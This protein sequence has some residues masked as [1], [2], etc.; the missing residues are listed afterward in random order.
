MKNQNNIIIL[1]AFL[2]ILLLIPTVCAS[3]LN[4][5]ADSA[6]LSS[7]DATPV[8]VDLASSD[9][10][11]IDE[12]TD[13][14]LGLS[15]E[16]N[17]T[18]DTD[19]MDNAKPVLKSSNEE[20][21]LSATPDGT[22]ADLK[23]LIAGTGWGKT[24]VLD[25][26][27]VNTDNEGPIIIPRYMTI[28]GN[29]YT[30]DALGKSRIF[31]TQNGDFNNNLVLKN[32][33]FKN[34]YSI[35]W[36]GAILFQNRLNRLVIEDCTFINCTSTTSNGAAILFSKPVTNS[37]ISATFI[38]N[39]AS[40]GFS[41]FAF[42]SQAT[43]D[44]CRFDLTF[45][46]NT[47]WQAPAA[48][49]KAN[50][51]NSVFNFNLSGNVAKN[52][53]G[54]VYFS[55]NLS[56]V[57]ITGT[58]VNNT[59]GNSGDG[60]GGALYFS[61][62]LRDV[63]I[64]GTFIGNRGK[65]RYAGAIYSDGSMDNVNITG[66]FENNTANFEGGAIYARS[67]IRNLNIDGT[68]ISNHA[69]GYGGGAIDLGD[70]VRYSTIGGTFIGNTG[71]NGG[72]IRIYN[73]TYYI[74]ITG[75]FTDNSATCGGAI[76]L[77][78]SY[79]IGIGATF[80]DNT[81]DYGGA[82]YANMS[83][84]HIAH[85]S[86]TGNRAINGSAIYYESSQSDIDDVTFDQNQAYSYSLPIVSNATHTGAILYGGDNILNAIYNSGDSSQIT[87]DGVTVVDGAENSQGGTIVYQDTREYNQVINISVYDVLKEST[88]DVNGLTDIYGKFTIPYEFKDDEWY[89]ISA[90]HPEDNYYTGIS[91]TSSVHLNPGLNL[92]NHT[93]YEGNFSGQKLVSAL[94]D[95]DLSSIPN[96]R[97]INYYIVLDG[98]Y[99]F[100]GSSNTNDLGVSSIV[101]S[102]VFKNLKAGTYTLFAKYTND[103]SKYVECNTTATLTVLPL[104]YHVTKTLVNTED[105]HLDD[106][107]YF[108]IT[109]YNDGDCE[110][111]KLYAW[112]EYP[113][114]I[115]FLVTTQ[116]PG[117]HIE[118]GMWVLDT[119]FPAH[120]S[121][122]LILPFKAVEIGNFTNRIVMYAN[123][124]AFSNSSEL[125]FSILPSPNM[126]VAKSLETRGTIYDNT[127]VVFEVHIDNT[128]DVDLNNVYL[129]E[130]ENING[131]VFDHYYND[132]NYWD[133][134]RLGDGTLKF[135][136]NRVLSINE[137]HGIELYYNATK[138]GNF[139]NDVYALC[140]YPE[141]NVT[142]SADVE[143]IEYLPNLT[144]EKVDR[145]SFQTKYVGDQ[146]V[147]HITVE[148]TGNAVLDDV[149]FIEDAY[150]DGL[151]YDRYESVQGRWTVTQLDSKRYKFTLNAPAEIGFEYSAYL[152]FN[153]TGAGFKNN[154]VVAGFNDTIDV[155]DATCGVDV[156]PFEPNASMEKIRISNWE[157]LPDSLVRF[158]VEVTNTGNMDLKYFY[159]VEDEFTDG[160]VYMSSARNQSW[161]V[162][163]VNG[164]YVFTLNHD[165]AMGETVAIELRFNATTLGNKT[166]KVVAYYSNFSD[167]SNPGVLADASAWV[168]VNETVSPYP[169]GTNHNITLEKDLIT[170]GDIYVGD[171]VQYEIVAHNVGDVTITDLELFDFNYPNLEFSYWDNSSYWIVSVDQN[172]I[173]NLKYNNSLPV[174]DYATVTLYF[175]AV[176]AGYI[177]NTAKSQW[178]VGRN[179]TTVTTPDKEVLPYNPNVD[180]T[181]VI[182]KTFAYVGDD[183]TYEIIIKNTGN[184]PIK[185]LSFNES[186]LGILAFDDY[187]SHDEW[188]YD[189]AA[190]SFTFN[191]PLGLDESTVISLYY[192]VVDAGR[193][194]NNVTVGFNENTTNA[195]SDE[196]VTEFREYGMDVEKVALE[197]QSVVGEQVIFEVV[198]RNTGNVDLYDVFILDEDFTSGLVYDSH[199]GDF[200]WD[201]DVA[202]HKFISSRPL[203]T[204]D[205][206]SLHIIFNAT[207]RGIQENTAY[208]G[209]DNN[210]ILGRDTASV[211]VLAKDPEI[212]IEKITLTNNTNIGEDVLFQI[213]IKNVGDYNLHD[214]TL[215]EEFTSGLKYVDMVGTLAWTHSVVSGKDVF[216]YVRVL[217]IGETLNLTLKFT[218]EFGGWFDNT[219]T[220][221]EGDFALASAENSTNV[222]H[223]SIINPTDVSVIYTQEINVPINVT[224]EF[225]N[226]LAEG[227]ATLTVEGIPYTV[228][229]TNGI[230]TFKNVIVSKPGVYVGDIA[231]TGYGMYNPSQ[232]TVTVTVAKLNTTTVSN[233]ITKNVTTRF[234]INANV[235]DQ[236]GKPVQNGTA[237]LLINGESHSVEVEDGKVTFDQFDHPKPGDYLA[238]IIYEGNDYYESSNTTIRIYIDKLVT[239]VRGDDTHAKTGQK[240][241]YVVFVDDEFGYP[242]QNG[243]LTLKFEGDECTL[244]VTDGYVI[245]EGLIAPKPGNYVVDLIYTGNDYYY[246]S[247]STLDVFISKL[248]TFMD[249]VEVEAYEGDVVN[250]GTNVFDEFGNDVV[251]NVSVVVNGVTYDAEIVNGYARFTNVSLTQ[252]GNFTQDIVFEETEIYLPTDATLKLHVLPLKYHVTKELVS[253]EDIRLGDIIYFAITFYN[254][255]GRTFDVLYADDLYSDGIQMLDDASYPGWTLIDDY[256]KYNSPLPAHSCISVL[257][258]FKVVKLGNW[259]NEIVMYVNGFDRRNSSSVNFTVLPSPNMSISKV[260]RNTDVIYEGNQ[261]IF[262]IEIVNTGDIDLTEAYFTDYKKIGGL[263][264]DHFEYHEDCW[265]VTDMGDMLK[266]SLKHA[267]EI[268]EDHVIEL[269]YNATEVGNFTNNAT[270]G[271]EYT[272]VSANSS[273]EVEVLPYNPKVEVNKV[274]VSNDAVYVG[275]QVVYHVTVE[276]AGDVELDSIY[277]IEDSYDDLI[278]DHFAQTAESW[279]MVKLDE[280]RYKFILNQKVVPGEDFGLVLYF[281]TTSAGFK[282]NTV[283]AGFNNEINSSN[284]TCGVEV[285]PRNVN[286]TLEKIKADTDRVITVGELAK[287]RVV[288]IN[289]G[290]IALNGVYFIEN[291]PD[292]LVY[293]D[294][295]QNAY[296]I[297]S[298]LEDNKYKF[299]YNRTLNPNAMANILLVFNTTSV[300]I[301]NNTVVAGYE[302]VELANASDFV[303]VTTQHIP[304]EE[305]KNYNVTVE[306]HLITQG[307]I[308]MGDKVEFEV[309][310]HNIGDVHIDAMD[311][312]IDEMPSENLK[313]VGWDSASPWVSG[314]GRYFILNRTLNVG[315][316]AAIRLFFEVTGEG[317]IS[318]G[319]T[320]TWN[321]GKNH[322]HAED[323][324]EALPYDPSI[325][326]TKTLIKDKVY[327]GDDVIYQVVIKNTGNVP[328]DSIFFIE[329]EWDSVLKF[330][331]YE[332]EDNWIFDETSNTFR[333]NRSL[334]NDD[335]STVMLY[336]KAIGEGSVANSIEAGF[337]GGNTIDA[338]SKNVT[339]EE[340]IINMTVDKIALEKEVIDGNQ[341]KFEFKIVNTG[342]VDIYNVFIREDNLPEGLVYD[343]IRSDVPWKY[344]ESTKTFT[345]DKL[346]AGDFTTVHLIF[347]TTS[348]GV[349]VNNA[350]FGYNDTVVGDAIANVSVIE[351]TPEVK[352]EKITLTNNTEI[353][354]EILFTVNVT[355]VGDY[356]IRNL[357]VIENYTRGLEFVAIENGEFWKHS[358]DS[359]GRDIFTYSRV[360]RI[361][362]YAEMTLKF[363]STSAG[364]LNNTVHVLDNDSELAKATNS[365]KVLHN[366]N[367]TAN[368]IEGKYSQ[369]V[370]VTAN[371]TDEEGNPVKYG[372]ATLVINGTEYSADVADGKAIFEDVILPKPG[373]Y[374]GNITYFANEDYTASNLIVD[375]N[376]AK[377]DTSVATVPVVG[378]IGEVVN[379]SV[380]VTDEFGR[381]VMN[382]T[383]SVEICGVT[384][385][386]NVTGGVVTFENVVLSDVGT[387]APVVSYD[388]NDYYNPSNATVDVTV[389]K[390]D[391]SVSAD[392]VSGKIGE[393]VNVSVNV[394][395]EFG[396][397]VM[398][399][400]A[401]LEVS[402]V[403]YAAN[404]TDGVVTFENVVLPDENVTADVK[405]GGNDYYNPSNGTVDIA[406]SKYGTSVSADPVSGKVGEVVNV[407][408]NVTDEFGRPVQNGTATIVVGGV[409]YVAN[410]TDGVVTF[411][412]VVLP[413]E[414]VT[415]DIKYE[416]NDYYSP[417]NATVGISVG[418]IKTS[419]AS[420]PVEGKP[421]D[422]V[423]VA[424]EV[425]DEFGNPIA[426]GTATLDINGVL[427]TANI[428]NGTVTFEG[429]VLPA[430]GNYTASITYPGDDTHEASDAAVPVSVSKLNTTIEADD[431][432]GYPGDVVDIIAT[433]LDENGK[434][435]VSGIAVLQVSDKIADVDS[436]ASGE[437]TANVVN[438]KA[439]FEKV[440]LSAPGIYKGAL[441][442]LGDETYN[443]SNNTMNIVVLKVPV[444]ISIDADSGKPGET[445]NV[446]VKVTPKDKS[447][448]NGVVTVRFPDGTTASVNVVDGVGV[449]QWVIPQDFKSGNYSISA[450][451]D[452]DEYY[453]SANASG[454][455]KVLAD[456]NDKPQDNNTNKTSHE[457]IAQNIAK[458]ETGNPI[459]VLLV[460]LSVIGLIPLKRKN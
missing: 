322:T 423:S 155:A 119:V 408:A 375:V 305:G 94:F 251:G 282:N 307:N 68:F 73:N 384:Y 331:H 267:L 41:A 224:D 326:A 261:V 395:D 67:S 292:G 200:H 31:T 455:V 327:V 458:H 58:F 196:L 415:A 368:D 394:A 459:L 118:E 168:Y 39:K 206:T 361:G 397:P 65:T 390:Y 356:N 391:T 173:I 308:Y 265:N 231:Y 22:F 140:E 453:G 318:N 370:N 456:N 252:V 426:N 329:K 413:D 422:V 129:I 179:S 449:T 427:Y 238:D 8:A 363:K 159:F 204:G 410:V 353:G 371:I 110:I 11:P 54:G 340:K 149:Y 183:V 170:H 3:D 109:F 383:A 190:R 343:S 301:K 18:D 259:S 271:C 101:E 153:A 61:A 355:N 289:E 180:V 32:I 344:D 299:T 262:K 302:D 82:V 144:V 148:N 221:Y 203:L 175:K 187:F 350:T 176:N 27:Y 448:F 333:L 157:V 236:F 181:K 125:D 442:Y 226:L 310:V 309:R 10:D 20:N 92:L 75:T 53:G 414:N 275:D 163:E 341:V 232:N 291:I 42:S 295:E 330:D 399:G 4:N 278:F 242:V 222:L 146:I 362:H 393:V 162:S 419:V 443:P 439:V 428:S 454:I 364:V 70:D 142:D 147:Y 430:P 416:G 137:T 402:G 209:C 260:L 296:W 76:Y 197:S 46:N 372:K 328:L 25:R 139:T 227:S 380:N 460:L 43:A 457:V 407:T 369:K 97:T 1:L 234:E 5:T 47:A 288:I 34:G 229:V 243:T 115:Q 24:L 49:F 334:T 63:N 223:D 45:I 357:I 36:G 211:N 48:N 284:A 217:T 184:T 171:T 19:Q 143:V 337:D 435:V 79:D 205:E 56:N 437:Y 151:V 447:T 28:D 325:A 290:N 78:E 409:T 365:T 182:D 381:P 108:N 244:N 225:G 193:V 450:V 23:G 257:V 105:I 339:V 218:S 332:T 210:V 273:V 104:H 440:V 164:K 51:S 312:R 281:N 177:S 9:I 270:A 228:N 156:L 178:N 120:S 377:L 83:S 213:N 279:T 311:F 345:L 348:H 208:A 256:A 62:I 404:V 451:F 220:A 88:I 230:A 421:G 412:N 400:T 388:G 354:S 304:D 258:P 106:N 198:I 136:L 306:K 347:N 174:N 195:S 434:P 320:A 150:T 145:T 264:Y 189:A 57:N 35:S 235:T 69:D 2:T 50:V 233:N 132:G 411:E 346:E 128:G 287:F 17:A 112:D 207:E 13:S 186:D 431:V 169:E 77:N 248:L 123:S 385:A 360:L 249:D 254:D 85:A 216:N 29:G 141:V 316:Y 298:K 438:G 436:A 165:F 212:T 379:V 315:G 90:N 117:W 303:N 14:P 113:T 40:N 294:S 424:A 192:N 172:K 134:T 188:I 96:A 7:M 215:V 401:T 452:G 268:G 126:T 95:D 366:T 59:A 266:F 420:E 37:N 6:V 441:A 135:T 15:I 116:F 152:Y 44:N 167:Y 240:V 429:V 314:E 359:Q 161:T 342:N 286:I 418:K 374:D 72:A 445:V 158:L 130:Y 86:F 444:D 89:I 87:V 191:R 71:E 417:S 405:Y 80:T 131:L 338:I 323:E 102:S 263:V 93:M 185:Y 98:D 389:S 285:L 52:F 55:G 239:T 335:V 81:A 300:G 33:V 237:T 107:V 324:G 30:I 255:C 199:R 378:K 103:D 154:T 84:S 66:Y 274:L 373:N 127:Q 246:S 396:R 64:D 201:Y 60:S 16:D 317:P 386:A 219:V 432:T 202:S 247:N 114:G 387:F 214:L 425:K 241:D 382:G 194:I 351:Q 277:F 293:I 133:M 406:V 99:K 319:V 111:T 160:L 250:F 38:E 297:M 392:S 269:I 12:A 124:L 122:S 358:T 433:V 349:K 253:Q 403:T 121:L 376:V 245:F 91:N 398:N 272:D 367:I 446:T 280:R 74:N 321:D 26:N 21:V 166:N 336:F 276:N 138:A 313:F 352:V 283:I 100:L